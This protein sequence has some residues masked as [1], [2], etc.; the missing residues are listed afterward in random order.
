[1][2][3]EG[4]PIWDITST[5]GE[6]SVMMEALAASNGSSLIGFTQQGVGA[7]PMTVEDKDRQRVCIFDFLPL[8][9]A[10]KIQASTS[11]FDVYPILMAALNSR[12]F[13]SGIYISGPAIY[14]PPGKYICNGAIQFKRNAKL[15]GDGSGMP[16]GPQ[17]YFVFPPGCSGVVIHRHNTMDAGTAASTTAG[18][19][20]IIEGIQFVGADGTPDAMGGHGV[21]FRAR[22]IVKNCLFS[23][24]AGDGGRAIATS[25][26]GGAVEGNCNGWTVIN[27]RFQNNGEWGW[28]VG[29][30]DCNAGMG[31]G[32]DCSQNGRGAIFDNS[33]LGNTYIQPQAAADGAGNAGYNTSRGKSGMV[34]FGGQRYTALYPAT[35]AQLAATQPGTD[36][37]IWAPGT[38]IAFGNPTHP[39]WVAGSPV[40]TYFSSNSYRFTNVN[41]RGLVINPYEEGGYS[42]TYVRGPTL[43]LNG[44][45][46]GLDGLS[47]LIGSTSG[48]QTPGEMKAES[49][50][51]TGATRFADTSGL[52]NWEMKSPGTGRW[53][54]HW[55]NIE[56]ELGFYDRN[57][58]VANG[59]VRTVDA[60]AP[61]GST[62]S[63]ALPSQYY[64][65]SRT[66]MKWRGMQAAAPTVTVQL[67][68]D[69]FEF[70][71]PVAGGFLGQ[72]CTVAGTPGTWRN[73]GEIGGGGNA[74]VQPVGGAKSAAV[75]SNTRHLQI[76][77]ANAVINAGAIVTF[78]WNST[79]I[80]AD[81]IVI[82]NRKSGGSND[83][84][85]VWCDRVAAGSCGISIK[86]ETG[87]PLGEVL[88]LQASVRP[89]FIAA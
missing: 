78:T 4:L 38:V 59:Y 42:Q 56:K 28:Q 30:A 35:D 62:G 65:G 54:Y 2:T 10:A 34:W 6:E 84:Y 75:N 19:G 80:G 13:H 76:T 8:G 64:R 14:C 24:F 69:A 18:D 55:A 57:A 58:T 89:S 86:N 17:P 87:A 48:L 68:G 60:T 52:F 23:G 20:S 66:Q 41:S 67:Q 61:I 16:G 47:R 3:P 22:G 50:N 81:D 73:F 70:L 45:M 25:G 27:T 32:I 37:T 85:S 82:V 83:S 49:F 21:W 5:V 71:A 43:L 44:A 46:T 33:F 39:L 1:M 40:G 74:V 72:V 12:T 77:T 36:A 11:V 51:F 88:V 53:M 79:F 26:G 15:F 31:I 29:G 7:V 9:E 63:F